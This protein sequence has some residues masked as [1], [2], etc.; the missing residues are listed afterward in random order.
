MTRRFSR[1]ISLS[2]ENIMR[3]VAEPEFFEKN[4]GLQP[5]AAQ[6]A[7]CRDAFAK[8]AAEKG[9]RCRAD[10][11]LLVPCMTAF[12]QTLLA[13]KENSPDTVQDFVRYAAKKDQIEDTGITIYFSGMDGSHDLQRYEFP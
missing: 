2:R 13:A 9:C 11:S 12:I 7:E 10:T 8:S 3:F 1:M 5:I 6:M 4:P